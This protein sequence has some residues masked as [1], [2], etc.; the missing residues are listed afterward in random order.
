MTGY[1]VP[2]PPLFTHKCIHNQRT[3]RWH[4]F[5]SSRLFG[6]VKYPVFKPQSS[7]HSSPDDPPGGGF[8][9]SLELFCSVL[10]L[11][12]LWSNDVS[13]VFQIH[14][15]PACNSRFIFYV[16]SS[17]LPSFSAVRSVCLSLFYPPSHLHTITCTI[18]THWLHHC[19]SWHH[20]KSDYHA[21]N[22][23]EW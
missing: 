20:S 6:I 7:D 8:N 15:H 2:K 19:Y 1:Q 3:E 22:S 9:S 10:C 13:P 21:N 16:G 4:R 18:D 12:V 17:C 23:P 14:S 5:G 11:L